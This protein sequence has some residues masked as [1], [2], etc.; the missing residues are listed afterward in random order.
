MNEWYWIIFYIGWE[1]VT[2]VCLWERL[3]KRCD[4]HIT[5][6]SWQ[7]HKWNGQRMLAY[8][9]WQSFNYLKYSVKTNFNLFFHNSFLCVP[10]EVL[11]FV[12]FEVLLFVPFEVLLFV[13]F[14]VLFLWLAWVIFS[15]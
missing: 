2:N 1:I 10:F 15:C 5:A 4:A 8:F 13:P 3:W 7:Y 11:L 14:E 9:V 12:P 6:R